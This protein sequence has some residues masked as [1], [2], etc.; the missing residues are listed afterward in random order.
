MAKRIGNQVYPPA[1]KALLQFCKKAYD[2]MEWPVKHAVEPAADQYAARE[3]FSAGP[4][5]NNLW[6]HG[7]S[8]KATA[9]W[10]Y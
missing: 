3:L 6:R 5:S 1:A 7:T 8:N 9:A 10:L 2:Q 4:S